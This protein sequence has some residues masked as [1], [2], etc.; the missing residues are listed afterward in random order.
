MGQREERL[1]VWRLRK[2]C[3]IVIV[4]TLMNDFSREIW[5]GN[6]QW[7]YSFEAEEHEFV[8]TWAHPVMKYSQVTLSCL[9]ANTEC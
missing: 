2:R 4:G 5:N 8:G 1:K 3:E 6:A 7:S 9:E